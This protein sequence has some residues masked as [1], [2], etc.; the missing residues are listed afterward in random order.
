LLY[1]EWEAPIVTAVEELATGLW[2]FDLLSRL[3]GAMIDM[4]LIAEAAR[5]L[6]DY[7]DGDPA[8]SPYMKVAEVIEAGIVTMYARWFTGDAKLGDRWRP[9]SPEDR[10]LHRWLMDARHEVHAHADR[11][12]ERTLVNT[13]AMLGRDGPPIYAERRSSIPADKLREIAPMC[14]RQHARLWVETGKLKH[15]LGSPATF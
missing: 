9:E 8:S 15:A 7:R 2:N 10:E 11:T 6:A 12:E 13:N 1:D 3:H 5:T 4:D 14:D